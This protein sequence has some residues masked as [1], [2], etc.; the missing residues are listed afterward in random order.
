MMQRL[1]EF[2]FTG[3]SARRSGSSLLS[4]LA[5][6]IG[7]VSTSPDALAQAV[8]ADEN[9]IQCVADG[10]VFPY[11]ESLGGEIRVRP[12]GAQPDGSTVSD[13]VNIREAIELAKAEGVAT[14]RLHKQ[15]AADIEGI[16]N[17]DDMIVVDG[18]E[19]TIAG[20]GQFRPNEDNPNNSLYKTTV[21]V[22]GMDC[23]AM[24]ADSRRYP[25]A[26][27]VTSGNVTFTAF[28]LA[29]TDAGA[30]SSGNGNFALIHYTGV[31]AGQCSADTGKTSSTLFGTVERMSLRSGAG[32]NAG[33]GQIYEGTAILAAAEGRMLTNACDD[34][35]LGRLRVSR[36]TITALFAGVQTRMQGGAQVDVL[37]NTFVDNPTALA[38]FNAN[39]ITS[40]QDNVV[41]FV[42][43]VLS[44]SVW[45]DRVSVEREAVAPTEND[46]GSPPFT[47][48]RDTVPETNKVTIADNRFDIDAAPFSMAIRASSASPRTEGDLQVSIVGNRID[49]DGNREGDAA[50]RA[51]QFGVYLLNTR[52]A[53]VDNNIFIGSFE[54]GDNPI[55]SAIYLDSDGEIAQRNLITFN[56]FVNYPLRAASTAPLQGRRSIVMVGPTLD[57]T[58]Q[59]VSDTQSNLVSSQQGGLQ[60]MSDESGRNIVLPEAL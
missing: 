12:A 3:L 50:R 7:G 23:E 15:C 14:V 49:I 11:V 22:A 45:V 35:L 17:V 19:G 37:F 4:A 46:G 36:N 38:V 58:G 54:E 30:C 8:S 26:F 25:A 9:G 48:S 43:D 6:L 55:P 21:N 18:F 20:L 47:F 34:S 41:D 16:F 52:N 1:S 28:D 10:N 56:N 59:I 40:F 31:D 27:K 57:S 60:A 32:L 39:Q 51:D 13:A 42:D 29:T 53:L 24:I 5:L 44:Y 2:A 33:M